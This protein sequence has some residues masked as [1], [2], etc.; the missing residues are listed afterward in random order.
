MTWP[1][2]SA[3][4]PASPARTPGELAVIGAGNEN[5]PA[6]VAEGGVLEIDADPSGALAFVTAKA[7]APAGAL[8]VKRQERLEACPQHRHRGRTRRAT[9]SKVGGTSEVRGHPRR[10]RVHVPLHR[11]GPCRRRHEGNA[12][13]SSRAPAGPALGHRPSVIGSVQRAASFS[14]SSAHPAT[15]PPGPLSSFLDGAAGLLTTSAPAAQSQGAGRAR[16][17]RRGG[18]RPRRP[19]RAPRRP[20]GGCRARRQHARSDLGLPGAPLGVVAEAGGD[21][22][23]SQ[24]AR[25]AHARSARR[26]ACAPARARRRRARRAAGREPRPPGRPRASSSATLTPRPG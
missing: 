17:S 4:R 22:R 6:A 3:A 12:R 11:T 2:T 21:Q 18:P 8:T 13:S 15:S 19:G 10:R 14:T 16:S 1:P 23:R 5:A 7:E 24:R 26:S 20:P 25:L 9:W